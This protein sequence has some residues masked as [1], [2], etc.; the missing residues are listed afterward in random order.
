ME[1]SLT[2]ISTYIITIAISSQYPGCPL[3]NQQG[4]HRCTNSWIPP[5]TNHRNRQRAKRSARN[6]ARPAVAPRSGKRVCSSTGRASIVESLGGCCKGCWSMCNSRCPEMQTCKGQEF[7]SFQ[8]NDHFKRKVCWS[9]L[10]ISIHFTKK[11]FQESANVPLQKGK[12]YL[13][14]SK[15]SASFRL[16]IQL[17]VH[18][19]SIH[20]YSSL[21]PHNEKKHA[22]DEKVQVQFSVKSVHLTA[23][24]FG[25]F[26]R[27]G[28]TKVHAMG[29][30]TNHLTFT[31]HSHLGTHQLLSRP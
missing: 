26:S 5:E 12:L 18:A 27:P 28:H 24:Y 13:K 25:P 6:P 29:N 7:V 17:H 23:P 2:H 19:I 30:A 4:F 14:P 31:N 11:I 10:S 20:F 21:S 16:F 8:G 1:P 22:N 9:T 3:R 15:N